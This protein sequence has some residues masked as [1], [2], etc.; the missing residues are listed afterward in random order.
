MELFA[1]D[2]VAPEAFALVQGKITNVMSVSK[3]DKTEIGE[4]TGI[5]EGQFP[6]T[7]LEM[8]DKDKQEERNV[9]PEF[10]NGV[11]AGV[12]SADGI[13]YTVIYPVTP[14]THSSQGEKKCKESV[15]DFQITND[16]H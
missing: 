9:K 8:D 3:F 2:K 10:L 5:M 6:K 11:G 13:K 4:T 7:V 15:V 12:L 14:L 1:P 16:K